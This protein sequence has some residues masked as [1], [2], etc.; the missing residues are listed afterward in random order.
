MTVPAAGHGEPIVVLATTSTA[1]KNTGVATYLQID[2][3][4]IL[5]ADIAVHVFGVITIGT[6]PGRIEAGR[7]VQLAARGKWGGKRES[8]SVVA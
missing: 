6:A 1:A 4:H 7:S 3:L 2:I 8:V 5:E